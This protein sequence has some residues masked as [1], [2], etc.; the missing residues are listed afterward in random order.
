[1]KVS[2][3]ASGPAKI[4]VLPKRKGKTLF[5]SII[6]YKSECVTVRRPKIIKRKPKTNIINLY[7]YVVHSVQVYIIS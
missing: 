1:M 3:P 2:I 6:K 7:H 5:F 4:T